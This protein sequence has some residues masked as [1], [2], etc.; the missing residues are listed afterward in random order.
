MNVIE[1]DDL[2]APGLELFA[3]L[4]EPQ[5]RHRQEPEMGIFIAESLK[6]IE[7]ALKEGCQPV[8]FLMERKRLHGPAG[9]MAA[10][11]ANIRQRIVF[12]QNSQ[13]RCPGGC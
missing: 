3:H 8:A 10:A 13:L 5:L 4:T 12:A 1:I 2:N 11:V 7:L 9:T 6:V